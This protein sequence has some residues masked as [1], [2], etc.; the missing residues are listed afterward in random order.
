MICSNNLPT[1]L[2]DLRLANMCRLARLLCLLTVL[3]I[4][5]CYYPDYLVRPQIVRADANGIIIL[6]GRGANPY[7]M[8]ALHCQ[9]YG[10]SSIPRGTHPSGEYGLTYTYACE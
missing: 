1:R 3:P 8:A 4:A 5:A 10:K 9:H 6:T 7:N 2:G